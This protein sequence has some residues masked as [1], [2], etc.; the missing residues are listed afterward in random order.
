MVRAIGIDPGTRSFDVCGLEN[1]RV[2]FEAVIDT[3]QLAEK[4][5]LMLE[6]VDRAQP[7][8]LIVGPSGYGV[9]VTYLKDVW[10]PGEFMRTILLLLKSEDYEASLKRR[11]LGIM[12]YSAM[13]KLEVE[14]K[15]LG[16]PVCY[17]PGVVQL[18]SVPRY[19]KINKLDMGTVDKMCAVV[20]GVYDQARRF[21]VP[22]GEVSFIQ[23]ESGFGYNAVIGVE[24]GRIVD[25]IGGTT[26]GPGFLSMGGMD[27]ELAAIAGAWEKADI[28]TGG[29]ISI[30]GRNSLEEIADHLDEES[31]AEAWQAI[32]EGVEKSVAAMNVSVREPREILISGRWTK[33]PRLSQE[34]ERR[35]SAYGSV[36]KV[37]WLEGA[38]TVKE[39]AQGYA[40]V[41]E[42]LAGGRFASL[43]EWMGIPQARGTAMDYIYHPKG[44]DARRK[45]APWFRGRLP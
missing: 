22:Y 20:L 24:N 34:L 13:I 41:A 38:K 33:V 3:P 18:P 25:G 27:A 4:P 29:G 36:R 28:F 44:R 31:C 7:V 19:R 21:G 1:G 9:E 30:T 2:Y 6:A 5:E 17:I 10:N 23:V 39:A 32:I 8:D 43:V 11:D 14:M 42:G 40:M 45:L 15:R 37:G 35:L 26:G 16:L 12:V